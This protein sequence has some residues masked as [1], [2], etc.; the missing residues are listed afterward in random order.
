MICLPVWAY[1]PANSRRKPNVGTGTGSPV[2]SVMSSY[3]YESQMTLVRKGIVRGLI[4]IIPLP[5]SE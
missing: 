3:I 1:M 5:A 2:L 4:G